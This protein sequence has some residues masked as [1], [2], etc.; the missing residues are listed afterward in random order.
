MGP[1][2]A[3]GHDGGV[4]WHSLPKPTSRW[5]PLLLV[6]LL[7]PA[8]G[9]KGDPIPRPRT[10][11]GICEVRM[12]GLRELWVRL[13]AKDAKGGDLDGVERVRVYYAPLSTVRPT[14]AQ[15]AALGDILLERS[16][17]DLP[18]PGKELKLDLSTI[19][20]PPGWLVVVA[21]RVGEVRG[22]PSEPLP[23]L[24]PRL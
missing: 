15:V 21:V 16:R 9:R 17:P 14:G 24:D 4:H 11:P 20:R 6:G 5:L 7:F 2:R 8:C 3:L 18:A 1:A 13:P 22:M 10:A 12:T 19:Q 23:W